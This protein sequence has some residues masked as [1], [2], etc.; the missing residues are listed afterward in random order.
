MSG[1]KSRMIYAS[2]L[3]GP[4]DHPHTRRSTRR[5]HG[6]RYAVV[7]T[8]RTCQQDRRIHGWV[9]GGKGIGGIHT[10]TLCSLLPMRGGAHG[11]VAMCVIFVPKEA[12]SRLST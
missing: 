1:D 7:L 9:L 8:A 3:G 11:D 6:P 4:Q 10:Q 12:L 5:T 2:C